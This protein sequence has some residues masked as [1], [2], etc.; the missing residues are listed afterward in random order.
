MARQV[1]LLIQPKDNPT[2][3]SEYNYVRI[4][5]DLHTHHSF[6]ISVPFDYLEGR[7]A[8][9]MQKTHSA[10]VGKPIVF[11][12]APDG[13]GTG[14]KFAFTG[15]VTDLVVASDND[16]TGSFLIRGYSPGVLLTDGVQKRT[17]VNQPLSAIIDQV[18]QPYRANLV[19]RAKNLKSKA[20]LPYVVQYDESNFDFLNRLMAE[21]HEWFFYDGT[22]LQFGLPGQQDTVALE[23]NRSWSSF[24]LE[25]AIR[26]GKVALHS[27]DPV[28]HQR[29]D[30]KNPVTTSGMSSNQFAQFAE[31]TGNDIFSQPSHARPP[32]PAQSRTD[33]QDAATGQGAAL[34][35]SSLLF[36]GRSENPDLRL[37][38]LIDATAEGLGSDNLG[39][40]NIGKYRIISLSHDVDFAG[41][42]TNTFTAVLHSLAQPPAN[43]QA[44]SQPG[45]PE[46]AEV[47]DVADPDSLG[48]VRVRYYW[49]TE[50][51]ADAETPW[52][53]VLTPYAGDGKGQMFTPEVGS[54]VLMHY[55][56]HR[57]EQALVLGNM[58]H[59]QN[60]QNAIYTRPQN[61]LKGIQTS[62]GNKFVMSDVA[63]EQSILI[64]NSNKK[65][66][67][68]LV[69][70]KGD[71]SIDI[72][73]NGPITMTSGDSISIAAKKNVSI[74]A[75]ED[76]TLAADKNILAETKDESIGIRAKKRLVLT[77]TDENL[78]LEA[79]SKKILAKAS[80]N[81]EVSA[82]AVAKIMGS[83]IKLSKS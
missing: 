51:P 61:Q 48:R 41:T 54:Q 1:K 33:V 29:W 70:F 45:L 47:I 28:Q 5:Q 6:E 63:G 20:A 37:G 80:D 13:E 39:T 26:P 71:G 79:S 35:A 74:R 76:I 42:Y 2:L 57:P 30:G 11:S 8:G 14:G 50:K 17:F 12:L 25:A 21:C 68:I 81:V 62:G 32:L 23:M 72:K 59:S 16:Y 52:L 31:Q 67:S 49:P 15:F 36:R 40:E 65:S 73:T 58:F 82:G 69:S 43:P 64:S 38:T 75:G 34:A 66:T 24:Q 83:D 9:F 18:L 78:A 55:E 22:T 60:K 56:H 77:A 53:R 4:F 46:L 3:L 7:Q 44:R 19:P 27:Y 10:L